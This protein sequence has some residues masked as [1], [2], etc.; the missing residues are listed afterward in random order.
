MSDD[1]DRQIL[2]RIAKGDSKSFSALFEKYQNLVYG[3][4]MKML[5][6][7]QKAEDVT[8]EAWMRVARN[9]DKYQPTGSVKS[10]IMS[11]ARNL[12]IDEF[13]AA[14]K[15]IDIPDEQWSA[16]EDPQGSLESFFYSQQQHDRFKEAFDE[17][18]ENQKV[19][20]TM[21]LVEELSQSDVAVKLNTSVG[22]VKA[23]LFRARENLKKKVEGV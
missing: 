1:Q 8:Q 7:K 17:L 19:I 4:S 23:S 15:W 5:K 20:L 12:V 6:D 2:I 21:V 10:W 16:I 11:I 3:Y 22:A 18:P 9:A 13:R 14:K